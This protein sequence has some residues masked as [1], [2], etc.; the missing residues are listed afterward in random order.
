[1]PSWRIANTICVASHVAIP[2]HSP[3][4]QNQV[5]ERWLF[6]MVAIRFGWYST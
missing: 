4:I 2:N 5:Y 6:V 3:A 1:M